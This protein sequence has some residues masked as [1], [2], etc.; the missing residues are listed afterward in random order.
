M[1]SCV[2]MT[3][4]LKKNIDVGRNVGEDRIYK[5]NISMKKL[6]GMRENLEK[7]LIK[8]FPWITFKW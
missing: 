1:E 4:M 7:A 2:T 8:M 3:K 6:W 5:V